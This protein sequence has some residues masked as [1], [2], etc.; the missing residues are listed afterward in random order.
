MGTVAKLDPA[1]HFLS[2]ENTPAVVSHF[3]FRS[4]FTITTNP[5]MM[6]TKADP[7]GIPGTHQSSVQPDQ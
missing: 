7:A 2:A 3:A 1:A 6:I 4:R 5:A